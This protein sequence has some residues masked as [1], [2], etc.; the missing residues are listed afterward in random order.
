MRKWILTG[1][2]GVLGTELQRCAIGNDI[3]YYTPKSRDFDVTDAKSLD[4]MRHLMPD[5]DGIVHCAAYT[6][7]PGAESNR[8]RAVEIN[9]MGSRNIKELAKKYNKTAVYISTDYVYPGEIGMYKETDITRPI[10]Y[11]ACTKLMGESSFD[12]N[13]LIIRTSFKPNGEWKFPKAFND[14]YTSADYVDVIAA[15]ITTLIRTNTMRGVINVGTGR[16]SIYELAKKRTNSVEKMSKD[17]IDNVN[18]P[19]DVSLDTKK[20]DDF[21]KSLTGDK[22]GRR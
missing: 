2:S 17:E 9:I 3:L 20:Y 21:Y 18:L 15:K 12:D 7:V 5:V 10:N 11:Y 13:D 19:S 6:D 16:K 22:H 4:S 1:G 14:V 8:N